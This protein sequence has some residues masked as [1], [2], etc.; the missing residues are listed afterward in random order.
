MS[1]IG[2]ASE[3]LHVTDRSCHGG[4]LALSEGVRIS[5]VAECKR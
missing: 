5:F 4:L 2:V 3:E 1:L